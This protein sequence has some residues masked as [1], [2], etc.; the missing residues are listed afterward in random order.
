M[1]VVASAK[2]SGCCGRLW[3]CGDRTAPS[4]TGI[5]PLA[6]ARPQQAS[7]SPQRHRNP[8]EYYNYRCTRCTVVLEHIQLFEIELK[9]DFITCTHADDK[10]GRHKKGEIH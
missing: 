5:P 9:T 6:T 4:P 7:N 2:Q 8:F 3:C 10:G 1:K